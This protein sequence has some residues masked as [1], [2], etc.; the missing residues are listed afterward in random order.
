M[1]QIRVNVA[2]K[3][4]NS[5][6]R[7]E[8]RN[9][10]DVIVVPSATLPFDV[11]MNGGLYPGEVIQRDYKSLE[12][13]P[14][15]LEHPVINGQYVSA[16]APEAINAHWVGAWNENVRIDGNRVKLDKVIDVETARQSKAGQRVLEAINAGDPIHTSTGLLV[17]KRDEKGDGYEWVAEAMQ[18]D[19][20]AILLDG[21]G[22][23]TPEQGVGMLVNG[24]QVPVVNFELPDEMLNDLARTAFWMIED[25]ERESR[26]QGMVNRMKAVFKEFFATEAT[27]LQTNQSKKGESMTVEKKDLDQ[28]K[29]DMEQSMQANA[30][31]LKSAVAEAVTNAVKPLQ[32]EID[33]LKSE[34]EA[35]EA[36]EREE[37]AG[38]VVKANLLDEE[39]CK[40]LEIN[41]LRKLA[42]KAKP[43]QA[44][45]IAPGMF[46]PNADQ[47]DKFWDSY[48]M[49]KALKEAE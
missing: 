48:D 49:N 13:T 36:K 20:D 6:I 29:A 31:S 37:L 8:K 2:A 11:V 12:G 26:M 32:E 30:D 38:V 41:A 5:K 45:P 16:L 46:Q 34:R 18:F 33:R 39:T 4:Q 3:V 9:G 17:N 24:A 28:L 7:K 40:T 1:S 27:G 19:H 47:D 25:A 22:A 14:A 10:R 15:P 42:A 23:A 21:P 44:A 43:G 35:N